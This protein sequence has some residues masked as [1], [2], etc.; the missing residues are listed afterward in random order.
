MC[1][2][3]MVGDHYHEK[4]P[5]KYPWVQPYINPLQ[6]TPIWPT[7]PNTTDRVS[8]EEFDSLK[9][10]VEECLALLRRAKKY[11]EDNNE[12]HCEIEEKMETIQKV[13]AIVGVDVSEVLGP[14]A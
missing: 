12:P 14:Q 8:R 13:A 2:V 9:K 5:T 3:S 6:P 4:W 11:D 7:Y 1:V 10:D